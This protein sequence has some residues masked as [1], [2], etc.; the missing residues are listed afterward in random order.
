MATT[1][2]REFATIAG[3]MLAAAQDR[4][5]WLMEGGQI[6]PAIRAKLVINANGNVLPKLIQGWTQHHPVVFSGRA[7]EGIGYIAIHSWD[8]KLQPQAVEAALQA[9]SALQDLPALVVDVRFNTGG[10]EVSA[11]EFAGCFVRARALYAKHMMLDRTSASG[12]S[13]PM[14]RWLEPTKDRKPYAGRV[15]VLMGGANMSSAEAF[16]LMMKQVPGCKLVGERSVGAS[17]NPQPHLLANGVS[18]Y[19]PSWKAMLPD[20]TEFETRGITPDIEV[21]TSQEDFAQSDPVLQAAVKA[22]RQ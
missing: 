11:R 20:G 19:L 21:K 7:A 13:A 3:E 16:L 17:G 12:F 18:V 15:A 9:L 5:I 2:P 8:K 6:V 4:H 22:L 14:E 10:D 1:T